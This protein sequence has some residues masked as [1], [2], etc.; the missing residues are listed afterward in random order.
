MAQIGFSTFVVATGD[1]LIPEN[2]FAALVLLS[3]CSSLIMPLMVK[4]IVGRPST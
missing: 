4:Y 3:F 2:L 1:R